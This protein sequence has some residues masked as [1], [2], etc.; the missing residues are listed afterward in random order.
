MWEF[1]RIAERRIVEAMARGEF[2]DLPGRGARLPQ[3]DDR[4]VPAEM[5]VA[6]RVL[7]N[8]GIVP[9]EVSIRKE[10]AKA[11]ESLKRGISGQSRART[12]RRLNLLYAR[13]G[14]TLQVV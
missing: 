2:D 13:L 14:R 3:D 6:Y 4:L 7:K 1:E 10:I 12:I 11:E 9:G 5:R 8:A